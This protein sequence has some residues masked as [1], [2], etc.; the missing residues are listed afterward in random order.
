MSECENHP[1]YPSKTKK[2]RVQTIRAKRESWGRDDDCLLDGE[3]LLLLLLILR[4]GGDTVVVLSKKS[5]AEKSH[6]GEDEVVVLALKKSGELR[7]SGNSGPS[8]KTTDGGTE[9]GGRLEN[10]EIYR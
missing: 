10:S 2:R 3:H 6:A 7:E 9:H 4:N 1:L 5:T 8:R